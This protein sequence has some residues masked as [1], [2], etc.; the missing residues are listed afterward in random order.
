MCKRV[1]VVHTT[2]NSIQE[3]K[4]AFSK[5]FPDAELVNIIDDSMVAEVVAHG[6]TPHLISRLTRYYGICREL[7]CLAILNQCTS[8]VPAAAIAAQSV[9]IPVFNID[10]PMACKA[11]QLGRRIGVVATAPSTLKPSFETFVNA[12]RE[13]YTDRHVTIYFCAGAHPALFKQ[14][15]QSL[16]DQIVRDVA[17]KAAKENDVIALAQCSM[18]SLAP[19]LADVGVPVLTSIESGVAQFRAV[20]G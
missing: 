9:D 11:A 14:G 5:A 8:V 15:N 19:A 6:I 4:Q 12:A 17:C 10:Y 18:A 2:T 13:K 16:H 20:L 7:G 3:I 1:A